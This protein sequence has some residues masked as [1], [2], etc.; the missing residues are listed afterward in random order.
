MST[1]NTADEAVK[2]AG[3]PCPQAP[4]RT[5]MM[6]RGLRLTRKGWRFMGQQKLH[7]LAARFEAQREAERRGE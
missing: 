1:N 5:Q 2:R 7:Q 6:P 4:R 3:A